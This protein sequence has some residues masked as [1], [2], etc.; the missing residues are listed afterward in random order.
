MHF[1]A[2][3]YYTLVRLMFGAFS[4]MWRYTPYCEWWF[5]NLNYLTHVC[6]VGRTGWCVHDQLL[7]SRVG[8]LLSM[9]LS[10]ERRLS[11]LPSW[12][13][14]LSHW[15]Y[16]DDWCMLQDVSHVLPPLPMMFDME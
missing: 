11:I 1:G 15:T 13:T 6:G 9:Y 12:A 14:L 7:H 16:I 10:P 8:Y 3:M 5:G 2:R 4:G